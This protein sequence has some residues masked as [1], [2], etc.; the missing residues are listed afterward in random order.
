MKAMKTPLKLFLVQNL[1]FCQCLGIKVLQKEKFLSTSVGKTVTMSC[2]HDDQSYITMLWYQKK[3]EGGMKLIAYSTGKD[4]REIEDK[5]VEDKWGLERPDILQSSLKIH[6]A[7]VQDS[8]VY[9]CASSTQ[10][11]TADGKAA[12]N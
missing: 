3:M 9:F 4:H 11:H 6:N 12:K 7:G 10:L 5:E 2:S 1:L 8:A